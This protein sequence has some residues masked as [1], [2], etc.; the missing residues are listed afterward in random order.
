ML[1]LEMRSLGGPSFTVTNILTKEKIE[2]QTH[3]Q[4]MPRQVGAEIKTMLLPAEE[5]QGSPENH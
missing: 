1:L 5:Y 3:M 2:T 4:G